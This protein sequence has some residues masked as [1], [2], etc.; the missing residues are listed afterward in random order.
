MRDVKNPSKR[1]GW[2]TH[3][4][5]TQT[6]KVNHPISQHNHW[7][8][9]HLI[10]NFVASTWFHV[11]SQSGFLA[12]LNKHGPWKLVNWSS[13]KPTR[14]QTIVFQGLCGLVHPESS[15]LHQPPRSAR[16]ELPPVTSHVVF[17]F[18]TSGSTWSLEKPISTSEDTSVGWLR[19]SEMVDVHFLACINPSK[20]LFK[21]V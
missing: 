11:H 13:W 19:S 10:T 8:D 17:L 6:W 1:M 7:L 4:Q 2:P 16:G 3:Q 15:I 14:F 12:S 5:Y 18:G 21:L 9:W 20:I